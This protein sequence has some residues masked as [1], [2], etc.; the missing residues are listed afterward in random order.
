MQDEKPNASAVPAAPSLT[1]VEDATVIVLYF[2][3]SFDSLRAIDCMH[4][5]S[6]LQQSPCCLSLGCCC[7]A[8]SADATT[9][10]TSTCCV[11]KSYK[12][13]RIIVISAR[14]RQGYAEPGE[15]P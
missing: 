12:C 15:V 6:A 7:I 1:A 10:H 8:A 3:S 13:C 5:G 11:C 9:K 4:C 14:S 2:D